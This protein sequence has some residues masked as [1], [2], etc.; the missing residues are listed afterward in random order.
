VKVLATE[1][2]TIAPKGY[3]LI[4]SKYSLGN[5][6]AIEFVRNPLPILALSTSAVVTI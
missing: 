2:V 5:T 1:Q 6:S 4:Q 3:Q